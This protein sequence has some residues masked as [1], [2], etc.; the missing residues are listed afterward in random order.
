M[1]LSTWAV[2]TLRYGAGILKWNKNELQEMD[3]KIRTSVTMSKEL[4]PKSDVA[5]LYVSRK[6]GERVLLDV[7]TV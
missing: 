6:N 7:E 5:Q 1:V 3:R 2:F 4:H